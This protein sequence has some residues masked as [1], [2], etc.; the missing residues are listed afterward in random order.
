MY[1]EITPEARRRI[2]AAGFGAAY[3]RAMRTASA[4]GLRVTG[5]AHGGSAA[6]VSVPVEVQ[7]RLW[8]TLKLSVTVPI[9][10]VEGQTRVAWTKALVFPGL[11]AGRRP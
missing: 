9:E 3:E 6:A 11:G 8:G 5:H 2:S 1:G 4:T 10:T 7:S